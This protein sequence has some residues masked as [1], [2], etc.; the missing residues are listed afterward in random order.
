MQNG[1]K[2]QMLG[3]RFRVPKNNESNF[4]ECSMCVYGDQC[5]LKLMLCIKLEGRTSKIGGMTRFVEVF[6][7][8][9]FRH[10]GQKVNSSGTEL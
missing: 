10:L 3:L 2:W 5:Q 7:M 9:I 6:K 1:P 8:P 4:D